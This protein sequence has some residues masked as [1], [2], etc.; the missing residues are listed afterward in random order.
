MRSKTS[1]HFCTSTESRGIWPWQRASPITTNH[2]PSTQGTQQIRTH[3]TS[4]F[5]QSLPIWVGSYHKTQTP[6]H[7]P[8][9]IRGAV[10]CAW[11][12]APPLHSNNTKHLPRAH[13]K[14][15]Q[16]LPKSISPQAARATTRSRRCRGLLSIVG[17]E[18]GHCASTTR[19]LEL[20]ANALHRHD[21]V[22]LVLTFWKPRP[23]MRQAF[24]PELQHSSFSI[25]LWSPRH[26]PS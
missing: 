10:R 1:L 23:T 2:Q 9:I 15:T 14:S 4:R 24:P 12:L 22:A 18:W 26:I 6:R 25:G 5:M 7:E 3:S 11:A 8:I 13:I 21:F 17:R 19:S 20:N 16:R